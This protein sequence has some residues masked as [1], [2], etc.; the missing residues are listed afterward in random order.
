MHYDA[1]VD[2]N[3]AA[4]VADALVDNKLYLAMITPWRT[5]TSPMAASPRLTR[6]S[7][8]P[9]KSWEQGRSIWPTAR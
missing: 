6:T 3:N 9:L 1:E 4:A 5:R 8:R 7:A 2:D